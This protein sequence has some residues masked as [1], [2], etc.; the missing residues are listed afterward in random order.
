MFLSN[1]ALERILDAAS[2]GGADFAEVFCEENQRNIIAVRAAGV[3]NCSQGRESGIGI[4]V[5]SGLHCYY[6]YSN[7]SREE[8]LLRLTRELTEACKAGTPQRRPL[9]RLTAYGETCSGGFSD[10]GSYET[11]LALIDRA[12]QAGLAYDSEICQMTVRYLDSDQ[13][14]LIANTEGLLATDRRVKTRM[15]ISAYAQHGGEIRSGFY[16]PG[17]MAGP[18]FYEQLDIEGCARRAAGAAKQEIHARKCPSG[19]M[20]VVVDNGFGGLM[21][22]EACGH[23]LE[24]SSV[25]KGNSEFSGR[26]GQQVA[27]PLVTLID[28][29]TM[30]GQWG[31]LHMD[32]EG[33]PTQRNVLIENGVLTGY[34]IDRLESRRM[35]MPATGSCRR[36]SYRFPPEARMTNTFIAPGQSTRDEIISATEKGLFVGNINGG[37]V[38]PVTGDFNFSVTECRLIENGRLTDPV[39]GATLIGNGGQVLRQVD[40]V[41]N[42]LQL[43]QGYCYNNSGALFVCAGQP[44]IRVKNIL[45][46]GLE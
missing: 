20:T 15:Q 12:I 27:S 10:R 14:I 18:E 26:L 1:A 4:R 30:P 5:F 19:M 29:G 32:D 35:G 43:G 37:S 16:G 45:V 38:D 44:T 2:S 22:H 34:M 40:M 36:Q 39:Y 11:K 24:A 3:D 17:A 8:T 31:S 7:D 6:A 41:G 21:F 28:D 23:S 25:S 9:G 13:R 42:N 33:N 46:G